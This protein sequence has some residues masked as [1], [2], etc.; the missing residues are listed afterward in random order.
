MRQRTE[1]E[2][3]PVRTLLKFDTGRRGFDRAIVA[4]VAAA[5]VL[6]GFALFFFWPLLSATR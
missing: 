3:K 6:A 4:L 2:L 5:V 1:G